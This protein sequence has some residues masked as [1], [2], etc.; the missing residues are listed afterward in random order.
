MRLPTG[1]SAILVAIVL[2]GTICCL[3]LSAGLSLWDE[4][5]LWYGAQRV[6]LGEVPIRDFQSYDPARYYWAAAF[7]S[8][9]HSDG[10]T[11]V[12]LASD[13][14]QLLAVA[15]LLFTVVRTTK[16]LE[17]ST[18]LLTGLIVVLWM[19]PRHKLYDTS[20]TIMLIAAAAGWLRS[21][22]RVATV[23]LGIVVGAAAIVGRNH[24]VYGLIGSILLFAYA[25]Q[26]GYAGLASRA[27]CF[28]AGV[29]IGYLPMLLALVG[30]HGLAEPFLRSISIMFER[31]ATNLPLPVPWPWLSDDP[32]G[33]WTSFRRFLLGTGFLMLLALPV[34]VLGV[35]FAA[36]REL[37]SRSPV[38][39]AAAILAVPYAHFAYSRADIGHLAQS[40]APCLIAVALYPYE[41]RSVRVAIHFIILV[42]TALLIVP[43]R[44][45]WQARTGHWADHDVV[46]ET[47]KL[48][49]ASANEVDAIRDHVA[50][51]KPAGRSFLAVPYW[52]GA[53][54]LMRQRSPMWEIY[55]LVPRSEDE[56]M[57]EIVRIQRSNSDVAFLHGGALDGDPNQTFSKTHP[58]IAQYLT[59]Q[60]QSTEY[61]ERLPEVTILHL[62]ASPTTGHSSN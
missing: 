14:F 52:P 22:S 24:G 25:H 61:D 60:A 5:Y 6:A 56:Q 38:A 2:V 48:Q 51:I 39:A 30:V 23:L 21:Q 32:F 45:G 4:G 40:I 20:T 33:G 44:P 59:T 12:R 57:K 37:Q 8:I 3:E 29:A 17:W 34:L 55:A 7:I 27:T 13:S 54:A 19:Y 62:R 9:L 42:F 58:L 41:R 1:K 26:G 50:D 16:L 46:G 43:E 31:G 11:V 49:V 35:R 47:L 18:L 10:I 36:R 15:A 28:A 53:Y